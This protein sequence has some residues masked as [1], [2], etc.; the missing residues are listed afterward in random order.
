MFWKATHF[1]RIEMNHKMIICYGKSK[2]FGVFKIKPIKAKWGKTMQFIFIKRQAKRGIL[3]GAQAENCFFKQYK[4]AQM[5]PWNCGGGWRPCS[6]QHLN[7][8]VEGE[9]IEWVKGRVPVRDAG[10]QLHSQHISPISSQ[11]T[12]WPLLRLLL[13]I[14]QEFNPICHL[15]CP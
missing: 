6:Q 11:K 5:K 1:R 13:E 15:L 8:V 10:G 4:S 9:G 12:F 3:R 7:W 14:C 2:R